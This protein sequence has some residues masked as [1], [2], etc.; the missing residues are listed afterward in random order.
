MSLIFESRTSDSTYVQHVGALKAERDAVFSVVPDGSWGLV[1]FRRAERTDVYLTGSTTRPIP[2]QVSAGDQILSVSFKPSTYAPALPASSLLNTALF[3]PLADRQSIWW[4]R[5]EQL[6]LPTLDSVEDFVADLAKRQH[7]A[8]NKAVDAVLRGHAPPMS[9]RTLQ[10]HFL[11]TTGITQNY[12][13][14][15]QRA[16]KAVVA[17][18]SGKSLAQVAFESGYVDQSHMTRWLR[19]IIGRTPSEIARTPR[20]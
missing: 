20:P 7:I 4:N 11:K 17:L 2:I 10:R 5:H 13:Q 6:E 9:P 8:Q 14:Q 16:Q 12:W 15:I 3:L 19:Q 1:I 18:H